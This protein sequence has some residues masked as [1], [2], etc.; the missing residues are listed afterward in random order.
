MRYFCKTL[1]LFLLP[2][3]F[4]FIPAAYVLYQAGEFYSLKQVSAAL[5]T[6]QAI[7]YGPAY[8]NARQELQKEIT[9]ERKPEILAIG[10]SRVGGFRD[11]FFK[12]PSAFYNATG[13]IGAMT[14]FKYF[15][16]AVAPY[17]P[18][19]LIANMDHYYFSPE[20]A[21][22]NVVTRPNP[23]GTSSSLLDVAAEAFV[24]NGGWWKI[25]RDY[26]EHKFT[27]ADLFQKTPE[28][29][30]SIGLR[31]IVER[32]GALYDGSDYYGKT[33]YTPS[34][35]QQTSE[36]IHELAESISPD[37]G[38]WYGSDISKSALAQLRELLSY[39]KEQHIF[40]IGF[41][42]PIAHEEYVR[43]QSFPNASYSYART[44]L[45]PTLEGI[46]REFGFDFYDFSD[47]AQLSSSDAEMI[48]Q[49]HGSEKLYARI[50]LHM[51]SKSAVLSSYIDQP[52][53]SI[54]LRNATSSLVLFGL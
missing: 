1:L 20:Q 30:K 44:Y 31:A 6:G 36:A 17:H 24:R 48:D 7:L 5:Q 51:A 35:Q 46:Y 11:V 21:K 27:L 40:V 52:S 13:A 4:V 16:E 39:C 34:V 29:K 53:L 25:Y 9:A 26:T 37:F 33:I 15:L 45:A 43:I 49:K 47:I 32:A 12:K 28:Q 3:L 18:Q 10:N 8:S 54:R 50:S 41:L 23:F 14:D 2:L 38:D 22:N 19:I 42:P